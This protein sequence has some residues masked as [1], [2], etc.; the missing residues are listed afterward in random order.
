LKY[1]RINN[2]INASQIRLID[3]KDQH[4]GIVEI[5]RALEIAQEKNLDLIEIGPKADPPVVKIMDFGQFKYNLKKKEKQQKKQQKIGET[6]GIRLTP[7]IGRH[8]FDFR[9]KKAKEFLNRDQKIKI[10]MILKGREKAHFDLA[11]NLIDQ[12]I[13]SLG[14]DAKIEQSP[15][16]QG[17][18][19]IALIS[20]KNY[21]EKT[22]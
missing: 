18:Q 15:K 12:F 13:N 17:N 19:L 6:K 1:Y 4:L 14:E 3:E 20:K 22:Q 9:V 11:K 21:D 7:R 8:D 2:K 5:K 16:R 10:E